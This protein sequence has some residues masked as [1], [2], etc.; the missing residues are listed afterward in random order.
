[1][2]RFRDLENAEPEVSLFALARGFGALRVLVGTFFFAAAFRLTAFFFADFFGV[3][4]FFEVTL[5]ERPF[6]AAVFLPFFLA[7]IMAAVYHRVWA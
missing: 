7:A 4:D 5:E 1:M 2:F 6:F 3:A